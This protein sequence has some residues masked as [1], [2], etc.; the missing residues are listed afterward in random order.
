MHERDIKKQF[1]GLKGLGDLKTFLGTYSKKFNEITHVSNMIR[2]R[3][4][5]LILNFTDKCTSYLEIYTLS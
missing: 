5:S 3:K 4:Y 2:T 1:Y